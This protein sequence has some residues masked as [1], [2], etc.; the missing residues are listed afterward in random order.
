MII[1]ASQ[2]GGAMALGQHLLKVENEHVELHEVRGFIAD[3]VMGAFKEAQAMAKSTQCK[4]FLFSVSLNPPQAESVRPE[5]FERAVETIEERL[6]L[7]G[8]PRVIIFHE[9]E[10]RRHAHAVW[11]RIDT[12]SLTARKLDF[13]KTKLN[14]LSREM[15]LENGWSMPKG[16]E[17]PKLRDPT[18]FTLQEWQQAKRAGLDPRELKAAVQDCWKRSDSVVAFA[19]AL[20]ER[21]LYL[22]RGDRRGHVVLTLDGEPFALSRLV[23]AKAKEV[24]AK[25]GDPNQLLGVEDTKARLAEK[26]APRL[27]GYIRDAKRMAASAMKPLIDERT[28][29]TAEHKAARAG[30]DKVHAERWNAEQNARA[31]RTRKGWAGVWDFLTGRYFKVRKQNELEVQFANERDRTE[32]HRLVADQ[33][34][35]RQALQD[36]IKSARRKE[37]EQV[38]ALTR[39]AARYRRMRD[40]RGQ[41]H[42]QTKPSPDRGNTS[43]R[44]RDKGLHLG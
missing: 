44:P 19:H 32:R 9:K 37:A 35:E 28:K 38:L 43:R 42:G 6:G 14:A 12:D 18:S 33:L 21:G 2:R 20:E 16:F 40:E 41:D 15:F 17:N 34:K 7:Q 22:A 31:S 27:S 5:V 13:F 4:K 10:G 30:L 29:L 24:T 8:Q 11:S 39:D 25:L 23:D 26:I 36:R 3:D 1:K